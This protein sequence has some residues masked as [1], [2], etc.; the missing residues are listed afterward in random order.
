MW[1]WEG[2]RV[3]Q[4]WCSIAPMMREEEVL[5]SIRCIVTNSEWQERD[6]RSHCY[7]AEGV[8]GISNS[9]ERSVA[10]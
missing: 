3:V 10:S 1:G 8:M 6:P 5:P 4:K 2:V 7:V 9:V